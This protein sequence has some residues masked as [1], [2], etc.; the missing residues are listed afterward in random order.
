MRKRS[1]AMVLLFFSSAMSGCISEEDD[2]R[3]FI[4]DESDLIDYEDAG[5]C[6]DL[7]GDGELDCPLSGYIPE[8]CH[9]GATPLESVGT[10]LTRLTSR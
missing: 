4:D 6:G 8:P 5:I 9:G 1:V 2:G 7:D 10:T 3:R